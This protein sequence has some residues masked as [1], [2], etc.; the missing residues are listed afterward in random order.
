MTGHRYRV[1][2]KVQLHRG[3]YWL[4]AKNHYEVTRQL[5]SADGE[6]W[7][8]IKSLTEQH[9]SFAKESELEKAMV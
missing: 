8:R 9:E 4:E 1:G 5:P 7:Y 6:F 3:C 2:Q